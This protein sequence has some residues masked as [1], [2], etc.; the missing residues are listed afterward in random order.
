MDLGDL[1]RLVL[2]LSVGG[3][4]L[5]HGVSKLRKGVDP[6][7]SE[8]VATGLPGALAKLVYVGEVV[9]PLLVILGVAARLGGALIAA[10]ML[11][12]V[13]LMHIDDLGHLGRGGGWAIELQAL[14]FFGGVCI[15]LLGSG[16]YG[17]MRGR[18][19]WD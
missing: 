4:F 1:A 16:H 2:R 18:G 3:M 15:A 7:V 13:W 11:V 19:N 12:A 8:L 6:I 10:T 17:I 5:M 14:Y 9:A